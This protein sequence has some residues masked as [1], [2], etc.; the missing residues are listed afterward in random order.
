MERRSVGGTWAKHK[1]EPPTQLVSPVSILLIEPASAKA[2]AVRDVLA[3]CFSGPLRMQHVTTLSGACTYLANRQ[4]D[5]VLCNRAVSDQAGDALERTRVAAA[6]ALMLRLDETGLEQSDWLTAALAYVAQRK[7]A[8]ANVR[9]FEEA[10]YAEKE[11]AQV[12]LN[13]IGDAVLVTDTQGRVTYLNRVAETMTGWSSDEALGEPLSQVFNIVNGPTGEAAANP[14]LAA[15]TE[16]RTVGLVDNCVLFRRDGSGVGIEDSAAPIHDRNG[17]VAGAVIVFRDVSQSRGMIRKMA[18]LAHHDTLT[19]LPNRALLTERLNQAIS[20]ARRHR[21]QVALLFLDLDHFK[22]INDSLGHTIGDQVLRTVAERLAAGVRVSDTVC[23]LGGDEFVILLSEIDEPEDAAQIAEKLLAAATMPLRIN[24]HTLQVSAS[25]GI[26]IHPDDGN[27]AESIIQHADTAMYQAKANGR[28]GYGHCSADTKGRAG[29]RRSASGDPGCALDETEL[30]LHY[31]PQFHVASG[32]I[33]GVEALVR[34]DN[35]TQGLMRP[36]DFLRYAEQSGLSMC[37]GQ[38]VLSEACRQS[39]QWQESGLTPLPIA[40]NI[41]AAQLRNPGLAHRVADILAENGVD[42]ATVTLEV[43]EEVLVQD[44]D[45]A[46]MTLS[47]LKSTG[48]QIA[49]DHF[50]AGRLSLHH[51]RRFP[52]DVLKIDGSFMRD[53]SAGNDAAGM[54]EMVAGLGTILNRRVVG[55]GVEAVEQL[56]FLRE[57]GCDTAQGYY[58]SHPLPAEDCAL[59]LASKHLPASLPKGV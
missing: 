38:W 42:P 26:S 34:W 36:G 11:R 31:Q 9:V 1:P 37:I 23:R 15:M 14:A 12:T 30:R 6:G 4:V 48:V 58:L 33:V 32:R 5:V 40:V 49:V 55:C 25:V 53:M 3:A 28:D 24:G 17:E 54:I 51:L 10:L 22:E 8:E 16:D 57:H 45:V 27:D 35:P 41:S 50:G 52:L 29:L 20:L 13:S 19:G 21:K 59:L 47:E 18:Y 7:V 43:P 56:A 46:A 39:R 2:A 44:A